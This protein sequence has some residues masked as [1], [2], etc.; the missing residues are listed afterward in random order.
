[1][2]RD[3]LREWLLMR[4][5]LKLKQARRSRETVSAV[6]VVLT[7]AE[8]ETIAD[9]LASQDSAAEHSLGRARREKQAINAEC[10]Q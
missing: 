10:Q 4:V 5:A 1:M 6:C 7:F 2:T 8:I 3:E 9:A